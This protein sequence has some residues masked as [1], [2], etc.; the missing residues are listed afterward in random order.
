MNRLRCLLLIAVL[1]MA[2]GRVGFQRNAL[3]DDDGGNG[4]GAGANRVFVT[5]QLVKPGTLGGLAAADAICTDLAS[6]AGIGGAYVAWLSTSSVGAIDR[7]SG[8]RGWV[9]VDGLPFADTA[10]DII[11]GQ[12]FYP[13]GLDD[14]G[15]RVRALVVT[16]TD[17]LG[18]AS[19]DHCSDL[20]DA[21]IDAQCTIGDSSGTAG[22]F[23]R[24]PGL[25]NAFCFQDL[26]MYC[27]GIDRSVVVSRP[28][29]MSGRRIFVST[30]WQP[31]AGLASADARCAADATAAGLTGTFSALLATVSAPATSR[32]TSPA[33]P[34]V[35]PDGLLVAPDLA[36]LGSGLLE[37]S[38]SLTASGQLYLGEVWAGAAAANVVA[39]GSGGCNDWLANSATVRA[40]IG[41]SALADVGYFG[42]NIFNVGSNREC[43]VARPLYCL[44][45]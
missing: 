26:P 10:A 2:C 27:F 31:G 9:R 11:S 16:T 15:V 41:Q 14:H 8:A 17:E 20:T 22:G 45:Q 37:T 38:P 39:T 23:T 29:P 25:G 32:F 36:A 12:I 42:L 28:A 30:D 24:M 18:H 40:P 19:A 34:I 5:S 1:G 6:N 13:I 7:I 43:N 3:G 35:R 44:E 4:D 33:G 21:S